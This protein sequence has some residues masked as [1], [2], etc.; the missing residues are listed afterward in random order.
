[1][2]QIKKLL[3]QET[4]LLA[5]VAHKIFLE[6]FLPLNNPSDVIDYADRFLTAESF[7]RDLEKP[8]YFTYGVYWNEELIGYIQMLFNPEEVYDGISFEL[9]RFYLLSTHHGRGLAQE[10]MKFCEQLAREQGESAFWLGVW[11]KNFKALRFY[12]KCGFKKI[13]SH[14][15]VMGQET[16]TD[17]IFAKTLI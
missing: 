2:L 5:P 10:M 11:E 9:K 3:L 7:A 16:Q 6:T 12:E 15:F 1:M 8:D 4:Q 13:A 14:P 17:F